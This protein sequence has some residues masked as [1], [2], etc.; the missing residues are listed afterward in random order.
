MLELPPTTAR[1][2]EEENPCL[3]HTTLWSQR[4][5]CRYGRPLS[6]WPTKTSMASSFMMG[7]HWGMSANM[8]RTVESQGASIQQGATTIRCLELTWHDPP[9]TLTELEVTNAG[10]GTHNLPE[11]SKAFNPNAPRCNNVETEWYKRMSAGQPLGDHLREKIPFWNHLV[12]GQWQVIYLH[13]E[14]GRNVCWNKSNTMLVGQTQYL[15]GQPGKKQRHCTT[16]ITQIS[17]SIAVI[18]VQGNHLT[19]EAEGHPL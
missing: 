18:Q 14:V 13:I 3:W 10:R 1:Q 16:L 6:T 5:K 4:V 17:L 19:R 12:P 7:H 2:T 8:L 11:M 15:A 9:V